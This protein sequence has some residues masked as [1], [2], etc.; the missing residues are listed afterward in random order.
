MSVVTAAWILTLLSG[1][2]FS[3]FLATKVYSEGWI[4]LG[5]GLVTLAMAFALSWPLLSIYFLGTMFY[6]RPREGT[7][8]KAL[9][10]LYWAALVF[11][12]L[13]MVLPSGVLLYTIF[14]LSP[15]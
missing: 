11:A 7:T 8:S 1:G 3:E 14:F 4:D 15:G 5:I 12:T 2:R 9:R 10:S 13:P 6:T